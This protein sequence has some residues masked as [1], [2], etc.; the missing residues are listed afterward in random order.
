MKTDRENEDGGGDGNRQR[1]WEWG[2]RRRWGWVWGWVVG[3]RQLV[4]QAERE[5][6]VLLTRDVKLLRRRLVPPHRA[7]FVK[8]LSK[9]EQLKEVGTTHLSPCVNP[10]GKD[11][12]KPYGKPCD[13]KF[14]H[15]YR[16]CSKALIRLLG[17]VGYNLCF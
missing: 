5:G 6:R 1:G 4:E 15:C 9:Q 8:S 13:K 10:Y 12:G 17:L 16:L 11:Y 2:W 3:S 7:L 14:R